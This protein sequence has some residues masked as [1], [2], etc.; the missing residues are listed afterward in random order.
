VLNGIAEAARRGAARGEDARIAG[1]LNRELSMK[2]LTTALIGLGLAATA[3]AYAQD[4]AK[5]E[6][7]NYRTAQR[8]ANEHLKKFDTLDFDVFSNQEWD[9]L[10]ESH[11]EN[12]VVYWPDGHSTRGLDRHIEDLK[13]MFTYAPDTRIKAHPV[14]IGERE[15]TAVIGVMEGTFTR[16]MTLPNGKVVQPTGKAF[17]IN[18]ATVGHWNGQGTMS[19]EYL[20]W[21]NQTYMKQLGIAD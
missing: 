19:E 16:P 4:K 1:D 14:K 8:I 7:E 11:A 21:D 3:P 18:M 10:K 15:W 20:F 17:K 12:I 2:L 5:V 13:Y 6:L 9:R